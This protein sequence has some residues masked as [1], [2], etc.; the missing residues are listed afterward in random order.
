MM[1]QLSV[2]IGPATT[3]TIKRLAKKTTTGGMVSTFP[4]WTTVFE[5]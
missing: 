1:N 5:R 4:G 2:T 3:S